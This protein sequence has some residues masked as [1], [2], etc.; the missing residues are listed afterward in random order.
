MSMVFAQTWSGRRN[1]SSTFSRNACPHRTSVAGWSSAAWS[2]LGIPVKFGSM[3]VT[4]GNVALEPKNSEI[5]RI[6]SN[7][8]RYR[9]NVRRK[10][11]SLSYT[12]HGTRPRLMPLR[13]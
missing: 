7:S 10:L 6:R 12:T 13:R 1:R 4:G 8:A 3:K 9:L 5:G 11:T 2:W